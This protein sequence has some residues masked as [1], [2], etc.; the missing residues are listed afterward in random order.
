MKCIELKTRLSGWIVDKTTDDDGSI[1][2]ELIAPGDPENP[3]EAAFQSKA[4]AA[5][6]AK[7]NKI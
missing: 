5:E 6:W 3:I 4:E 1:W 2:Y 7:Q